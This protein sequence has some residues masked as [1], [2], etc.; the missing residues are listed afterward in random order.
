MKPQAGI[1]PPGLQVQR[2]F[3]GNRL[4][5]DSQAQA[6]QKVFSVVRSETRTG[7]A[8]PVGRDLEE[9]LVSQSQEGVAA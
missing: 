4:A 7:V 9:T 6:Y 2:E 8:G 1:G 5:Q 3:E